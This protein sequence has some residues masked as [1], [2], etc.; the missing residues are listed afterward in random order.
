MRRAVKG[1]VALAG[2][3]LAAACVQ[4][5]AAPAE[6]DAASALVDELI[7]RAERAA[8]PGAAVIVI[9]DGTVVKRVAY[10]LAD[11]ARGGPI[12]TD[13][14]FRLASVSKQFTAMAIMLLAEAGRLGYDD[15]IVRFLPEL[16]RFGEGVHIRHLLTHTAGL[17]DY[18]DVMVQ[19]A[20]V[21]RP[22]TRHAL[23]VF[24][25]WGEPRFAPGERHEYSNP[26]YELLALIVER[27][28][29]RSYAD[30][31]HERI[32]APLGM[33][34]S[35]VFDERA[36]PVPKRAYGYRRQ[37][38]GFALDDDDPL[39]YVIG[40]GGIY[41]T[42]EDLARWDQALQ[43]E[44]LV[45]A[46]TLAQAFRPTRLASGEDYP[47]GF[48]WSLEEHLGRR[49]VA[50]T[51][52]WLGFRTA[53]ARYPDDHLSVIVLSNFAEMDAGGLADTIAAA[54]LDVPTLI[55][56]ASLVDGTGAPARPASVR[57]LADRVVAVGDLEPRPA[58]RIVD[59]EGLVLAPGFI[60]THSHADADLFAHPDALAALSQG[61]TTAIVGQD[62][63]SPASLDAFFSRIEREGAAIN[64][65]AYA[66][67]GTLRRRVLGDDF[68]RPATSDEIER[69]R[70]LLRD[71]LFAGALGLG[72][73]LE[74]EPDLYAPTAEVLA[75]AREAALH[76]G[77]YISH[78]RSEDRRFWEAIEE[79][80]SIGRE[81]GIPVQISPDPRSG[82]VPQGD[83]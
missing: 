56:G 4:A 41:S 44:R 11:L 25:R 15:P 13:T 34:G 12:G 47:Y 67:F 66:G 19:V 59:A 33:T 69:M 51:G 64:V 9:R 16:S 10:G 63:D 58:E 80:L 74:Y 78:I 55:A 46:E 52:S 75:L 23:D 45:R 28:S 24:S 27:A 53:I 39:N 36:P 76:G 6:P 65:A 43:G 70:A 21:E 20:G 60:D 50:H 5:P 81:A 2:C 82:C 57:I 40:S 30:F 17:P 37:G 38:D 68:R 3:L 49:R 62:G 8:T 18:Y 48:G 42:A 73:G 71:E 7:G 29:G 31:L 26:G 1:I 22:H 77:R 79:I 32:F 72:T 83:R 54:Y 35:V 61:I 14:A